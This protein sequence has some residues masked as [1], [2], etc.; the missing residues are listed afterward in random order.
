[1]DCNYLYQGLNS[2]QSRPGRQVWAEFQQ[3]NKSTHAFCC[4]T[5]VNSILQDG[6]SATI[7]PVPPSNATAG[8]TTEMADCIMDPDD[9]NKGFVSD[10]PALVVEGASAAGPSTSFAGRSMTRMLHFQVEY[11]D[12]NIPLI[13]PDTETIG[14]WLVW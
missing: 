7:N 1:M 8:E 4:Q 14:R 5:A 3:W 9:H 11:R 10:D 6:A 13:L 12:K 2:Y